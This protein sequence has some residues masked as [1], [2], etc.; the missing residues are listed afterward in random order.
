MY[1]IMN[2]FEALTGFEGRP[3]LG[4]KNPGRAK[5]GFLPPTK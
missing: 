5:R 1:R 3:W 2:P 4:L